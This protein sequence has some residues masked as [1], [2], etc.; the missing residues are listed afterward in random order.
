MMIKFLLGVCV[1]AFT[2]F[3]GYLLG[4][5]HRKKKLFFT[6]FSLFNERFINEISYY[7][8]PLK[9]F[10]TKY[11]YKNEFET[12]L[13]RYLY[14]IKDRVALKGNLIHTAD[15]DFLKTDE[16]NVVEDYFQMLGK[17]DSFSQKNYFS[18]MKEPLSTLEKTSVSTCK[19]YGDLYI[20][21]GFLCGLLILI[22]IL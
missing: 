14:C 16:K 4:R 1:V 15:F 7:R 8:H 13:E 2:T 5:K 12:L 9:D 3:I 17:G 20:K 6:Q 19:K 18:S 21:L 10:I 22:L 11:S